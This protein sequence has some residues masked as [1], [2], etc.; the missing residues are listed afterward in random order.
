M[1]LAYATIT[2]GGVVGHPVG[3]TSVK[4]LF[5]LAHGS[6]ETAVT[7]IGG[8]GYTGIEI[9]DGGLMEWKDRPDAFRRLLSASGVQL[10][11]VYSGANFIYPDILDDELWRIEQAAALA[12][13][14][15]AE[16]LTVGG[17][18]KRAAGTTDAD[19]EGLAVGL[20]RV[21]EIAKRH[22]LLAAYHPHLTTIVEHADQVRRWPWR[23]RMAA[24]ASS[25]R[26]VYS[27]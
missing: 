11:G 4:D 16:V 20:D 27:G 17:G 14:F 25:D 8:V 5:Y 19:Y 1:R 21:V 13:E 15:G 18:A 12:E 2:W 3:V 6:T 24:C 26:N 9:F 7:E 22:G 23:P 10:V